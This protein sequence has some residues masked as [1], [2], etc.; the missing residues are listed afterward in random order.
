MHAYLKC[1]LELKPTEITEGLNIKGRKMEISN[2]TNCVWVE[3]WEGCYT[4]HYD[5]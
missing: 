5:G 3:N 4:I 1:I 2:M